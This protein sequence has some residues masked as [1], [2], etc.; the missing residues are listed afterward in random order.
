MNAETMAARYLRRAGYVILGRNVRVGHLEL[1]L[2]A[3]D[4][5]AVVVV[6]VRARGRGAWVAPLATIDRTK[7]DRLRRAATLLWRGRWSRWRWAQRVRFDV[8]SV[9]LDEAD[10]PRIL[11]VRAAFV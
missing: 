2:V 4:G 6:E 10:G 1:D 5:D 3:R 9:Y 7:R 11:H 8:M